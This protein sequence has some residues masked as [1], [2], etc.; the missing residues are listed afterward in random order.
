MTSI[1]IGRAHMGTLEWP[2]T[3]WEAVPRKTLKDLRLRANGPGLAYFAMHVI[4]LLCT[5][6]L[7]H[8]SMGTWTVVPAMFVHGVVIVLLFAPLHEC[9]HFTAFRSRWLNYVVGMFA[10]IVSMRPFLYFKWRHA[11]H[12]TYTQAVERDPDIVRFP[13]SLGKYLAL[14]FGAEFW[15]KMLGT[16]WRGL[17]GRFNEAELRFIPESDLRRVSLEIRFVVL[18]YVAVAVASV[19]AQSWAAVLYWVLPRILGEPVLR[20]IRMAEHTGAAESPD[21][22]SN[23]RTTLTNPVLRMLYWNMPFHTEHHLATS[24]PFHALGRLH[25]EVKPQLANVAIGYWQVHSG[26]VRQIL[27]N[28]RA[29]RRQRGD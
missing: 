7:V 23:T 16:L 24:V 8:F 18:F 13:Q 1:G 27:T 17:S 11:E 15:P 6:A 5:G 4:A 26:I 29:A 28:R 22:L 2:L 14:V 19:A 10:G 21:L 20:A 9:S 12:H 3:G 25:D